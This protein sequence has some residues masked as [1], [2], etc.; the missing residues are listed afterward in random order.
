VSGAPGAGL[1]EWVR[2]C[3]ESVPAVENARWQV[4]HL[5]GFWP[6]CVRMC[7]ESVLACVKAWPQVVQLKGFSPV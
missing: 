2:A 3:R 5:Y 7:V 1:A 4:V 6:V